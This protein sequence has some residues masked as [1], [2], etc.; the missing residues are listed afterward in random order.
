[1]PAREIAPDIIRLTS[2]SKAG[3]D[4]VSIATP[5]FIHPTQHELYHH[6]GRIAV[7]QSLSFS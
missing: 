5:Y 3:A 4:A 7:K 6:Y 2:G 1:M